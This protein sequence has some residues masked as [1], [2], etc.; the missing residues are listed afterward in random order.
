MLAPVASWRRSASIVHF[1]N[2][3]KI[4]NGYISKKKK[5]GEFDGGQRALHLHRH[6]VLQLRSTIRRHILRKSLRKLALLYEGSSISSLM[7]AAQLRLREI[8]DGEGRLHLPDQN[9]Q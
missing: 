3:L 6:C 5:A 4:S 8:L 2:L 9:R 1:V 7:L